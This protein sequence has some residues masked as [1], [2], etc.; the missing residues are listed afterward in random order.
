MSINFSSWGLKNTFLAGNQCNVRSMGRSLIY[1]QKLRIPSLLSGSSLK[2]SQ[3]PKYPLSFISYFCTWSFLSLTL[4]LFNCTIPPPLKS[5]LCCLGFSSFS[6]VYS[7]LLLVSYFL[8][9]ISLKLS[10]SGKRFFQLLSQRVFSP[11]RRFL[12]KSQ[13]SL[14]LRILNGFLY[15]A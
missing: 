10:Q 4:Y 8:S 7:L 11:Q 3:Y 2:F 12:A 9:P 6:L 5:E 13:H 1:W 14:R 15:K